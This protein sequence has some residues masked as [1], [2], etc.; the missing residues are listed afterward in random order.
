MLRPVSEK[1]RA[2]YGAAELGRNKPMEDLSE[3]VKDLRLS[4]TYNWRHIKGATLRKAMFQKIA[5][6]CC[7]ENRLEWGQAHKAE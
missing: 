6:N 7:V 3:G 5:L 2:Q 1:K 4:P